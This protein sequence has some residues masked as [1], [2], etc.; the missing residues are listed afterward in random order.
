[1]EKVGFFYKG[2]PDMYIRGKGKTSTSNFE[3][4]ENTERNKLKY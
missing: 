4:I 1:M 2:L 3:T